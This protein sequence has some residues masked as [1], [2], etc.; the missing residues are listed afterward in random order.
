MLVASPTLAAPLS[1]RPWTSVRW[2][3]AIALDP[4]ATLSASGKQPTHRRDDLQRARRTGV[5]RG[6]RRR[7]EA[8]KTFYGVVFGFRFDEVE[9]MA[10]TRRSRPTAA[11]GGRRPPARRGWNLFLG[12]L[13]DDAVA[14]VE[15]GGGKVTMAAQDNA[16]NRNELRLSVSPPAQR[17]RSAASCIRTASLSPNGVA[18]ACPRGP[19][20]RLRRPR[21]SRRRR[22]ARQRRAARF[23]AADARF[24]RMSPQSR[25]ERRRW[26]LSMGKRLASAL[27]SS[28]L[29][30]A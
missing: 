20:W 29:S 6:S 4:Q 24:D 13:G 26:L 22:T 30:L 23:R 16:G 2:R 21:H 19:L 10:A 3:M 15:Q 18:R 25:A 28:R 7:I 14:A 12:V 27:I 8:A 1:L 11:L 9:G 17:G 5:E